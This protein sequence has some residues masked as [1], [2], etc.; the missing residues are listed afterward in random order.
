MN[1]NTKV[2]LDKIINLL[3]MDKI[4]LQKTKITQIKRININKYCLIHV[5]ISNIQKSKNN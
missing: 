4:N 5:K 2:I 3:D 1:K